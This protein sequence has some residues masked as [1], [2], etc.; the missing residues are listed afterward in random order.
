ME[1]Y[2]TDKRML[3]MAAMLDVQADTVAG[4]PTHYLLNI[5][6]PDYSPQWRRPPEGFDGP[7]VM[8]L[9]HARMT[10]ATRQALAS[11]VSA[12]GASR[13]FLLLL[14]LL[15]LL[16]CRQSHYY[17]RRSRRRRTSARRD[18]NQ[19]RATVS[20]CLLGT[21]MYSSG[22]QTVSLSRPR[23]SVHH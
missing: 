2:R 13:G 17:R 23:I 21:R 11:G 18:L 19:S 20:Q 6:I 5:S 3:R 15:L 14:L 22:A 9:V 12:P 4:L 8:V 7:G 16:L 1:A 10:V